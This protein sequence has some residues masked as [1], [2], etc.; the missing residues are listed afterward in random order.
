MVRNPSNYPRRDINRHICVDLL[1]RV[2]LF[3]NMNERLLDDICQRLKPRFYTDN[4]YLIRE[5]DPVNEMLFIVRGCLDSETTDGLFNSGFLK[6]GDFCGAELLIWAVDPESG[7]NH[8]SSTRTLKAARDV[9]AFALPA[10]ELKFV[11]LHFR[12]WRTWAASFIQAAW[13]RYSMRKNKV[14]SIRQIIAFR[15]IIQDMKIA[16]ELL[17]LQKPREPYSRR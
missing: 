15:T 2:P 9:E 6:E 16:K 1:K 13:R 12:H 4:S 10:E 5:G 11:V 7:V 8:P 14:A 17:K 3:K